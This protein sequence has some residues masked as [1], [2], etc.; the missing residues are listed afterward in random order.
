MKHAHSI[1]YDKP[2]GIIRLQLTDFAWNGSYW[3]YQ[4]DN[5]YLRH[6]KI[7]KTEQAYKS[8]TWLQVSY[9]VTINFTKDL[10]SDGRL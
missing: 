4:I 7:L 6:Y 9:V 1:L 3:L 10:Y 8:F 5:T 2:Q